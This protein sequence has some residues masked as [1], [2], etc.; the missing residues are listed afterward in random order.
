MRCSCHPALAACQHSVLKQRRSR[1]Q[2]V[3]D[4]GQRQPAWAATATA[5]R[6]LALLQ[7]LPARRCVTPMLHWRQSAVGQQWASS[8]PTVNHSCM[9]AA[10]VGQHSG[11]PVAGQP[12]HWTSS[13]CCGHMASCRQ[14]SSATKSQVTRQQ[15]KAHAMPC[16]EALDDTAVRTQP[17]LP[18]RASPGTSTG[19]RR[20]AGTTG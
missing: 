1:P 5:K 8:G 2:Q 14:H 4:A 7:G 9:P 18:G 19:S 16:Q 13:S 11:G 20:Q 17:L 15:R 3:R 12:K 6:P 10:A